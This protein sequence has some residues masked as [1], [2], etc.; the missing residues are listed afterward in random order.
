MISRRNFLT[1]AGMAALAPSLSWAAHEF[2]AL[3]DH[4]ILGCNELEG[5]IRFVEER[6]GVRAALGGVHPDRGTSNALLSLGDRHYLEIIAPDPNAKAVQ[7]WAARQL[8]V[9]KGLANP[10]L[11][12]WAVHPNDIEGLARKLRESGL[13]ILGPWPGSR[14]RADGRIVTWKSF[15]LADDRNGLLPFFIEWGKDSVHPSSDAPAGCQI[16]RFAIT[17]PDTAELSKALRRIEVDAPVEN[18]PTPKL[19]L[20]IVGSKGALE[21]TS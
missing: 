3:L 14:T 21:I 18:S 1:A 17:D 19:H 6:T 16:E 13:Q 9:L 5:G 4:I 7:A 8:G 15:S 12:G 10:R 2:P 20:R 11:I